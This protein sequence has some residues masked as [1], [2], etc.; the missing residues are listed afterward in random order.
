MTLDGGIHHLGTKFVHI[1]PT[2]LVML[3]GYAI[4]SDLIQ[5]V[6]I[7]MALVLLF[8]NMRTRAEYYRWRVREPGPRSSNNE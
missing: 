2:L 1:V 5:G 3:V 7:G 8:G 4:G 6:A